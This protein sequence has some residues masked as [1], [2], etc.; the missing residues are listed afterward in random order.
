VVRS[1]I[2]MTVAGCLL[3]S[4]QPVHGQPANKQIELLKRE[5]E[6][7]RKQCEL[8]K[9]ENEML[10]KQIAELKKVAD[11]K[12][13]ASAKTDKDEKPS[14]TVDGVKYVV[15]SA[16]RN[17]TRVTLSIIATNTKADCMI[18]PPRA[19]AVD[20]DGNLY[21]SAPSRTMGMGSRLRLREGVKTRFEV[22]IANVP[23][24]ATEFSRV[25][26]HGIARLGPLGQR[27]IGSLESE[28][29]QFRKVRIEN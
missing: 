14:A 11:K 22:V 24:S 6:L 23:T 8:A 5:L 4:G 10:R 12:D 2:F 1:A 16:T 3:L 15:D 28:S 26:L 20:T 19:E 29:A 17:G 13:G 25:E 7:A 21:T 27:M 9:Q 18:L